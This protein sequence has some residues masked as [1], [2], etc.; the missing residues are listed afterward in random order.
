[1]LVNFT[2][3]TKNVYPYLLK[4]ATVLLTFI[5]SKMLVDVFGIS[6]YSRY[7]VLHVYMVTISLLISSGY[8]LYYLR[9]SNSKKCLDIS[10]FFS[11]MLVVILLT[12][13]LV[14]VWWMLSLI[15]PIKF[16]L[17]TVFLLFIYSG[18]AYITEVIRCLSNGNVYVF[19]KD[20]LRLVMLLILLFLFD[21][22]IIALLSY[23]VASN[24][25]LSIIFLLT[26]N[27]KNGH[28]LEPKR[29]TKS[30][31][32]V[33]L[34]GGAISVGMFMNT[35]KRRVEYFL[36]DISGNDVLVGVYDICFKFA[37]IINLPK[38]AL[39]ADLANDINDAIIQGRVNENLKAR[40]SYARKLA[41]VLFG[42]TLLSMP[43]WFYWYGINISF[44]YV[45][46]A[47][48]CLISPLL[49]A[50]YGPV[51]LACQLAYPKFFTWITGISLLLI[52][53]YFVLIVR[54]TNYLLL[55]IGSAT[56]IAL[57]SYQIRLKLRE[58]GNIQF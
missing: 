44:E 27:Y 16:N 57:V 50:Y 6:N 35:V 28:F 1:M 13:F 10:L 56:L 26:L 43:G 14:G 38:V 24:F 53:L 46:L 55:P 41:Y 36:F 42:L 25:V 29:K 15:S 9:N 12:I 37:Q 19:F 48:A 23:A 54:S 5:V 32:L 39:N 20:S 30:L 51:Q 7:V 3:D 49:A 45:V 58:E 40:I 4:L 47:L 17:S 2:Y 22:E 11:V 34:E 18:L 52:S 33:F 31:K 8:G 21:L